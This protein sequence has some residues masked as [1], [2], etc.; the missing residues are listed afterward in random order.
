[1]HSLNKEIGNLGE[2]LAEKY[3]QDSGYVIIQKNFRCYIGEIDLI[4]KE[5]DYIIF[6]EVKT[7]YN[8][9]FGNPCESVTYCKQRR[10]YKTAQFYIMINKIHNSNFRFDV[11]E[12]ILDIKNNSNSIRQ[13][14]NAFQI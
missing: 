7:R 14:K 2:S 12:I 10:I 8:T 13:I 3:L 9:R 1:M 5:K 4:A 6:F 11:I